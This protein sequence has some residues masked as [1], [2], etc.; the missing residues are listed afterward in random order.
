MWSLHMTNSSIEYQDINEEIENRVYESDD[1]LLYKDALLDIIAERQID[2]ESDKDVKAVM[3]LLSKTTLQRIRAQ[4][5]KGELIKI[6][7]DCL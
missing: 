6:I 7:D 3:A 2:F 4:R 5:G 1:V